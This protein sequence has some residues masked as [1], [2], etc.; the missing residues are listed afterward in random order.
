MITFNV[1]V[2]QKTFSGWLVVKLIIFYH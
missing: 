2:I 1:S